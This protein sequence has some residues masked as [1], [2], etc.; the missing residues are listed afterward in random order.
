MEVKPPGAVTPSERI[1][2]T[3]APSAPTGR[4]ARAQEADRAHPLRQ[5]RELS[6]ASG[7]E[8]ALY[9]V[10]ES[11]LP[12]EILKSPVLMRSEWAWR[13]LVSQLYAQLV[14]KP[15]ASAPA[16]EQ[17][18]AAATPGG[19]AASSSTAPAPTEQPASAA[20]TPGGKAA[21]S[22]IEP[23]PAQEQTSAPAAPAVAAASVPASGNGGQETPEAGSVSGRAALQGA[24][25]LLW[26]TLAQGAAANGTDTV[27]VTW[28][29]GSPPPVVPFAAMDREIVAQSSHPDTLQSWVLSDRL[30]SSVRMD[31]SPQ[32]GGGLFFP[33]AAGV[34]QPAAAPHVRQPAVRWQAERRTR[35]SSQGRLV[36]YLKISLPIPDHRTVEVEL[37][38]ARPLLSIHVTTDHA[39]LRQRLSADAADVQQRMAALGWTVD[40]FSVSDLKPSADERGPAP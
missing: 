6:P 31:G 38:S 19:E 1:S 25:R 30:V 35:V 34:G 36:H 21:S 17:T 33:Y 32:V 4:T 5:A 14:M 27:H 10:L 16:E 12:V 3:Q 28:P 23:A 15:T 11:M 22:P 8:R 20:A 7:D 26:D 2:G 29:E 9:D 40:R 39:A 13:S 24:I 37:I 18:S